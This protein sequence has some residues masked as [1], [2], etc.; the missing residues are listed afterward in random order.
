MSASYW[1]RG[2]LTAATEPAASM[3]QVCGNQPF[4]ENTATLV[5]NSQ[6]ASPKAAGIAPAT[7][8]SRDGFAYG[9]W[10]TGQMDWDFQ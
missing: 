2:L 1:A 10:R 8:R 9:R 6:Q 5:A 4:G 7:L 3:C